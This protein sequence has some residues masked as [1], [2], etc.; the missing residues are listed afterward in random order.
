MLV[1]LEAGAKERT[2]AQKV[3]AATGQNLYRCLQ[4]AKCGGTCSR[5]DDADY[6][7]RQLVDLILNDQAGAVY[8]SRTVRL[9]AGCESCQVTCPSGLNL[10][11][12]FSYVV[13]EAGA[14]GIRAD[15]GPVDRRFVG[16]AFCP[17]SRSKWTAERSDP[18]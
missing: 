15:L 9:C 18:R 11:K 1:A 10:K 5:L 3:L 16:A 14:A 8:R 6:T 2:M 17:K 13:E 12:V 7:P 4:C